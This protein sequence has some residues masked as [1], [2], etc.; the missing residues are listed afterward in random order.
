[1]TLVSVGILGSRI[2]LK[3]VALEAFLDLVANIRENAANN[4]GL[5]ESTERF[6]ENVLKLRNDVNG[7][8]FMVA[9]E[10]ADLISVQKKRLEIQ[11]YRKFIGKQFEL[12]DHSIS[13]LR[14]CGRLVFSR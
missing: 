4:Q 9:T 8:F 3:N 2:A 13:V 5:F 14:D 6:T 7:K 1:M 10:L 11:N 12:M